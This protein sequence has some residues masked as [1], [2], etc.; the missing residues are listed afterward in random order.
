MSELK[1]TYYI[2]NE[3]EK[4]EA[5][6]AVVHLWNIGKVVSSGRGE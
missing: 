2:S 5:E 6:K 4:I 1:V 3:Q